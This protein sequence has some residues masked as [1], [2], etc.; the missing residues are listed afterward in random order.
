MVDISG[1]YWRRNPL[2]AGQ[3]PPGL[4]ALNKGRLTFTTATAIEFD[5]P[6]SSVT[7]AVSIWGSLTLHIGDRKYV[8][9]Q[10]VGQ[11]APPFSKTQEH[12][13]AAATR[14]RTLRRIP[15]WPAILTAAGA[16][17]SAPARNY[18]PWVLGGIMV[19]LAAALVTLL[20]INGG[21]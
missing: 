5:V 7:G 19:L 4:L 13:I 18:R 15:D 3:C 2:N 16:D 6:A 8:L 1:L 20:V 21:F 9:L 10:T 12:A 17:V 11:L 14:S